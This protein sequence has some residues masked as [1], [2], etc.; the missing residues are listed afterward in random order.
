MKRLLHMQSSQNIGKNFRKILP[1]NN[2]KGMTL[3]PIISK[4]FSRKVE[5]L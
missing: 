3:L 1:G 4:I 5:E 2:W